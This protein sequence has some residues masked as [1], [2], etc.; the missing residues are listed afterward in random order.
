MKTTYMPNHSVNRSST[1]PSLFPHSDQIAPE[2]FTTV[3]PRES[4]HQCL[5]SVSL[6]LSKMIQNW[7]GITSCA[8]LSLW[9]AC[10]FRY[11]YE[12]HNPFHVRGV[13]NC[14]METSHFYI[15][16]GHMI[17]FFC[18]VWSAVDRQCSYSSLRM[19]QKQSRYLCSRCLFHTH[20]CK[21]G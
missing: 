13:Q 15:D 2:L 21:S 1:H 19:L 17:L 12:L 4:I 3:Y 8:A 20:G 6:Q 14:Q 9:C 10:H 7:P 5:N 16:Y 11:P 18:A